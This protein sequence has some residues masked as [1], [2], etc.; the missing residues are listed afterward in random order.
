MHISDLALSQT[1]FQLD[2]SQLWEII[3]RLDQI[4]SV[5]MKVYVVIFLNKIKKQSLCSMNSSERSCLA[6][7][8]RS[9]KMLLALV[10]CVNWNTENTAGDRITNRNGVQLAVK[11][12]Q[13]SE[14]AG[15]Y[16]FL[17]ARGQHGFGV[18]GVTLGR[19]PMAEKNGERGN[20]GT[21]RQ[22]RIKQTGWLSKESERNTLKCSLC[23]LL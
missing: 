10:I 13:R 15:V 9:C 23:P 20:K 4:T 14:R 5:L 18:I 2:A 22:W 6:H 7:F 8:S 12:N 21:K 16:Y 11:D 1:F 3:L 17:R 19:G